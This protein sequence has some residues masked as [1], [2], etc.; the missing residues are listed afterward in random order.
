[1]LYSIKNPLFLSETIISLVLNNDNEILQTLTVA[2]Y[3]P[4]LY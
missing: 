3:L 4:V 2:V 1:L